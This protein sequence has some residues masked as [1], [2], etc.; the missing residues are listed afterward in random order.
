MS[1][2]SCFFLP[3]SAYA[4]NSCSLPSPGIPVVSRTDGLD[5]EEDESDTV[6]MRSGRVDCILIRAS[7][8][9]LYI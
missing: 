4:V 5:G 7:C 6:R 2:P 8:G 3:S 9:E 1:S